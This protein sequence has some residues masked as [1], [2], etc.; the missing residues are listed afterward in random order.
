MTRRLHV[1]L[2]GHPSNGGQ[3]R[4]S[5]Y[6]LLIPLIWW[7]PTIFAARF[8]V[9]FGVS[10]AP[11][12]ASKLENG[13]AIAGSASTTPSPAPTLVAHFDTPQLEFACACVKLRQRYRAEGAKD[14]PI[15]RPSRA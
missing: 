1:A 13:Y 2:S 12:R 9:P 5:D 7:S 11:I 8:F 10:I 14:L 3:V 15:P 4:P 6:T